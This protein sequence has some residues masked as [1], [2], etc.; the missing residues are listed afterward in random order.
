MKKLKV[1]CN[2]SFNPNYNW[3]L[4]IGYQLLYAFDIDVLKRFDQETL[5]ARD[6]ETNESVELNSDDYLGLYNRSKHQINVN[7]SCTLN[8]KRPLYPLGLTTEV[9]TGYLI[10]MEMI[11]LD[12]YDELIDAYALFDLS[13]DR[14]LKENFNIQL[15]G[16]TYFIT[17]IQNILAIYQE[18]FIL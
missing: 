5:Y 2:L 11:F 1:E 4:N 12:S 9:N 7:V 6:P 16:I 14:Q 13:I 17:P 15:G 10:Q 18:E 8:E 3:K